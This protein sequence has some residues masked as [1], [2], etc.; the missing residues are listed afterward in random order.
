MTHH[1]IDLES[2]QE[3]L[4]GA[5]LLFASSSKERKRLYVSVNGVFFI[6]HGD[7]IVWSGMQPFNAVEEYNNITKPPLL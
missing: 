2:L 4:I 7:K 6:E 1:E 3:W 5:K